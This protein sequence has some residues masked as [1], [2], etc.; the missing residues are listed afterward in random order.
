[1]K[2]HAYQACTRCVMD[3]TDPLIQFDSNG[4][5]NHC[6]NYDRVISTGY[7][8]GQKGNALND[9][10]AEVKRRG[11]GKPY[12]C[13][14]GV[15]GG[16]D[17]TYTAYLTRQL[18]LRPLAVHLDNGWNSEM[19]VANI[20]KTLD[21]LGIDLNT[22]VLDWEEF[23][24]LQVAFL[25]A[26]TPDAEIPTDHAITNILYEMASRYGIRHIILGNNTATEGILPLMWSYGYRD[27]RYIKSVHDR[28]GTVKLR[29]F[30]HYNLPK[31]AWYQTIK[32]ITIVRVLDYIKYTRQ[33]ALDVIQGKLGWKNYGWKHYESIYT[34]FFHGY[35]LPRKFHIDKRRAH[36]SA[37]ICSGQMPRQEALAE[38]EKDPYSSPE[39][40]AE[41]R[42]YVIKKLRLTEASFR[43]IMDAP[44]R[45][46]LDYPNH[47]RLLQRIIS[48]RNRIQGRSL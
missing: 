4:V 39:L 38:L 15:S 13:I 23:R 2:S 37:L 28:F 43:E 6:R 10:V 17:S 44:T 35:I 11:K 33:E 48:V 42:E 20:E 21:K 26:S 41:D 1:M 24:D 7:Y 47:Y 36:L 30:H 8:T 31:L 14:I 16:V 27:W 19:A 45:N 22:H 18:G 9:I 3:T 32:G 40:M 34:R 12:D 5:C 25:K 46:F 29:N